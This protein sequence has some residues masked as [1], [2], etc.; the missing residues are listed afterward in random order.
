[1]GIREHRPPPSRDQKQVQVASLCRALDAICDSWDDAV[2][3]EQ[4]RGFAN[5]SPG[6][7]AAAGVVRFDPNDPLHTRQQPGASGKAH[8]FGDQTGNQ[9]LVDDAAGRWLTA[10]RRSLMLLLWASPADEPGERRWTGPFHPPRLRST[11]KRA[12]ED[13]VELWPTNVAVLIEKIHVLANTARREWPP[14]PK[15]GQTVDGVVVGSRGDTS[16]VC[17]ECG[18]VVGANASDP[19]AR[20]DGKP[21]HRVPCYQ[22]VWQRNRRRAQ[23]DDTTAA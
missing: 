12:A 16:E 20:I 11:F 1:M 5:Q 7:R 14:T 13:V 3:A 9:A 22:T 8:A 6:P 15:V 21:Y 2:D 18:R 23:R 10:A 19:L 17:T 4:A